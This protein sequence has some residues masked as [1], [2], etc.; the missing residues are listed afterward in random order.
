M[1]S[2]VG[3]LYCDYYDDYESLKYNAYGGLIMGCFVY[4]FMLNSIIS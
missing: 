4:F 1:A 2:G 3:D